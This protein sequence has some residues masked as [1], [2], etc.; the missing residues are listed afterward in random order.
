MKKVII[1]SPYAGNIEQNI[2][3]ARACLKDSLDRNEAPL[4]SHLL[5]TQEGVLDD[6]VENERMQ[7]I[8]AGLAWLEVADLHVFYIDY[9]MSKGM[10]YARRFSMGSG[11][12]VEFR[13]I[14][15]I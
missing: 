1:E 6:T 4:A 3:Y 5:Y 12:K 13:K 7:G 8:N 14:G 9:G 15:K 11:V 2:K 10:E